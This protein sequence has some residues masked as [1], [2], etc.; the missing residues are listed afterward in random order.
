[1]QFRPD[2]GAFADRSTYTFD[3]PGPYVA[4]SEY[5][6][7]IGFQWQWTTRPVVRQAVAEGNV[8]SRREEILVQRES[9]R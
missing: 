1:M 7:H 8:R 2:D 5:A 6:A 3:R 4:G 9:G